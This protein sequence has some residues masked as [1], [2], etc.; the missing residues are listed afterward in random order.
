[1]LSEDSK[2]SNSIASQ[3]IN[4]QVPQIVQVVDAEVHVNL[5]RQLFNQYA[6]ELNEDLCFQSFDA[7]LEDPLKKYGPPHSALLLAFVQNEA[8][9][10]VAFQPIAEKRVCEMKRLY[11][12][13][14]Y[15]KT[16]LGL[17]L[18][19]KII[20]TAVM[21][22]YT[23]M[24]LDTLYRLQ[25]AI[26]LYQKVGFTTTQAYY[27]NPLDGVVYMEKHISSKGC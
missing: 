18:V 1:M 23:K 9:G 16:G 26:S 12:K 4:L 10:C 24:V 20:E 17:I 3:H 11:V 15:R 22:G 7:E 14:A 8:A 5:V 13:P 21:A 2:G 19:Q 6:A 25:A 27:T